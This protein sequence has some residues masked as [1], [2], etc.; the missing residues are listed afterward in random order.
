M[1]VILVLLIRQTI[2]YK[3]LITTFYATGGAVRYTSPGTGSTYAITITSQNIPGVSVTDKL[4]T[5]VDLFVVSPNSKEIQ[6]IT[7][8]LKCT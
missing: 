5:T 2:V 7:T 3:L 8:V 6:F 1:E 4:P